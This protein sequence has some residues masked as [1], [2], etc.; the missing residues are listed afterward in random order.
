MQRSTCSLWRTLTLEQV[1]AQKKTVTPWEDCTAPGSCQGLS[2]THEER[3]PCWNRFSWRKGIGNEEVSL[4]VKHSQENMEAD[5]IGMVLRVDRSTSYRNLPASERSG[6]PHHGLPRRNGSRNSQFHIFSGEK[7]IRKRRD[8][9]IGECPKEDKEM[10]K[11]LEGQGVRTEGPG[12]VQPGEE[13]A[14]GLSHHFLQLSERRQLQFCILYPITI[15][16]GEMKGC[17]I[18]K[19]METSVSKSRRGKKLEITLSCQWP[20]L[21]GTKLYLSTSTPDHK[22]PDREESDHNPSV[23]PEEQSIFFLT[24]D[25][26]MPADSSLHYGESGDISQ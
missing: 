2:L 14:Q 18:S 19:I 25:V 1:D 26:T 17:T 16:A 24:L 8:E 4:Y 9:A 15:R 6:Y 20:S 5:L 12:V 7:K 22:G 23:S 21:K 13:E 11:G 3:C 10:G